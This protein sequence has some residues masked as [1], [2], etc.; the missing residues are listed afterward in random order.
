MARVLTTDWAQIAALYGVL[1]RLD[2]NPVVALNHA[3]A[4]SMIAGLWAGPHSAP[5]QLVF[6]R[7]PWQV[8]PSGAG[9]I[10]VLCR[11]IPSSQGQHHGRPRPSGAR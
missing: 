7:S 8:R 5:A 6:G 3:G 10:G 2:D 9:A 1:L 11:Q 4:I